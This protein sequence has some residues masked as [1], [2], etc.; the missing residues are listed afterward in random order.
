LK[1]PDDVSV[2]GFDDSYIAVSVWPPLTTI[3]QP[4]SEM[5]RRA[6]QSLIARE[7]R[8]EPII[9]PHQLVVRSSTGTA[10]KEAV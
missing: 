10:P 9:L 3:Y 4:I 6:A 5:A 7:T 1:I 8:E 2:V